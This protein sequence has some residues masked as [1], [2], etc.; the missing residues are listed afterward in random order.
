MSHTTTRDPEVALQPQLHELVTC[1]AAPCTVLSGQDGQVRPQGAQG[2][3]VADVRVLAEAAVRFD[4]AEADAVSTSPVGPDGAEFVSVI[5]SLGDPSPDPSVWL[6]RRRTADVAGMVESLTLVN[7]SS[8]E[9]RTRVGLRLASDLLEMDRVKAGRR[10]TPALPE[11]T[12]S[13]VRFGTERLRVEVACPAA[14]IDLEGSGVAAEWPLVVGPRSEV[15]VSWSLA[16]RDRDA[17]VVPARSAPAAAIPS[18]LAGDHRLGPLVSRSVADLHA[19]R[20]ALPGAPADEFFAA[21]S[22]WYLTLFGRDS[23]WA[24]RMA[25]PLGT[26]LAAGTLRALASLQGVTVDSE[27]DEQPGKIPHEVRRSVTTLGPDDGASASLPPVYYGT[28]DA[29]PLWVCLLADAWRWGM[30]AD[31][32]AALL[33]SMERALNWMATHGDADGDGFLDYY[34]DSGRGLA[35]QGWKDSDDSVRFADGAIAAGPVALAEVQGY[36][37]EAALSGADLLDAFGRPGADRWRRY[38]AEMA[39]RFRSAFWVADDLGRFPALALDR[40]K[41]PVDSPASNMGHLLATGILTPDEASAVADRLIHPSMSSGF[42]LRT[43]SDTAGGYSA[44]SYHCGSVWPHDTAI[45]VHGLIKAGLV[46]HAAALAAGLLAAGTAFDGRLPELFGGFAVSD[47][48]VPVPYPASCRPQAWA[49]AGVI[50][51]LQAF[52]GLDPDVPNGVV[53]LSPSPSVGALSVSGLKINGVPFSVAV[54]ADGA[55]ISAVCDPALDVRI[56]G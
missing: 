56:A 29:T 50:V 23:I 12:A 10:G 16:V 44:L 2:A 3:F 4:G 49:A 45:A 33:P 52:L 43:M 14:R 9:V 5:R 39:D 15:T 40:D 55:L 1:L 22:P 20:M 6:R 13:G 53:R 24:A 28:V 41:R 30:P 21:G 51:M 18:V 36:A 27:T 7:R 19:L 48:V 25:L 32:V 34:D 54:G 42:G 31:E 11:V 37:Y 38:A 17:G 47:L 35:N 26:E 46:R 8:S